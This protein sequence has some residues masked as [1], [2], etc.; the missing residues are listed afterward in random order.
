MARRRPLSQA[1]TSPK[2]LNLKGLAIHTG[3]KFSGYSTQPESNSLTEFGYIQV[4]VFEEILDDPDLLSN[5][6]G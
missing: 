6:N 4:K 5:S 3:H 1:L 2:Q